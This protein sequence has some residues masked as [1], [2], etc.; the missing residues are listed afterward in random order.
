MINQNTAS[1]DRHRNSVD[2]SVNLNLS[3]MVLFW[4]HSIGPF[5]RL[6]DARVSEPSIGP[7]SHASIG[8]KSHASIG[9]KSYPSIGRFRSLRYL[10]GLMIRIMAGSSVKLL[11]EPIRKECKLQYR[12]AS[13]QNTVESIKS[14]NSRRVAIFL[15]LLNSIIHRVNAFRLLQF[16]IKRSHAGS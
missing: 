1:N 14:R 4:Q 13:Y 7:F 2:Q 15:K 6:F 5:S 10:R 8:R 12:L 16:I 3:L 9:Q 11:S